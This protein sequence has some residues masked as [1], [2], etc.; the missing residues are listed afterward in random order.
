[1]IAKLSALL[2]LFM[3]FGPTNTTQVAAPLQTIAAASTIAPTSQ[4]VVIT[5]TTSVVTITPPPNF[6]A[7]NGG[8][9]KVLATGI[10]ATTTA[11]NI[12]AIT[13]TTANTFYDFCYFT[14]SGTSKW[15]VK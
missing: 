8:C 6:T 13:T 1:M 15:Y 7:T 5:G 11:G 4:F 12:F 3:Q 10:F 9:I 2:L 14:V